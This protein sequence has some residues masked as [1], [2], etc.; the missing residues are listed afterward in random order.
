MNGPVRQPFHEPWR[1]TALRTGGIALAVA[2]GN[3]LYQRRPGVAPLTALLALWFTLGGHFAELLFRN[4]LASGLGRRAAVTL[5]ARLAYWF[6]S[7]SILYAGALVTWMLVTGRGA[8]RW[9]WWAGG[10]GFVAAEL[11]VHLLLRARGQANLYDA[12]G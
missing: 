5:C 2:L 1:A 4:R 8:G 11:V 3:A 12:N 6:A 10:A 7:G 9:P